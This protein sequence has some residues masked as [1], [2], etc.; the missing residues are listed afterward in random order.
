MF[1][2]SLAACGG[3]SERLQ[4]VILALSWVRAK[5]PWDAGQINHACMLAVWE[6]Q[7]TQQIGVPRGIPWISGKRQPPSHVHM[8]ILLAWWLPLDSHPIFVNAYPF[9]NGCLSHILHLDSL[10]PD[11][12]VFAN[13]SPSHPNFLPC[14]CTNW[15]TYFLLNG[16]C[17]MGCNFFVFPFNVGKTIIDHP[18]NHHT[19][20]V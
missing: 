1:F 11:G 15:H 7:T 10:Q 18:P 20:V 14:V 2:Q 8:L 3:L 13:S 4:K 19:Q 17:W 9:T 5:M 6:N 12:L 16:G